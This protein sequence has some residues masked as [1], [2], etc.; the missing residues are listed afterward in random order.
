MVEVTM[1][2]EPI[3]KTAGQMRSGDIFKTAYGAEENVGLYV[4]EACRPAYGS[5]VTEIDYHRPR[6][7]EGGQMYDLAN[8]TEIKFEV[9]GNEKIV[10]ERN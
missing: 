4:F 7:S 10:A 1:F 5:K 6:S 8:I 9:V 2:S 3:F